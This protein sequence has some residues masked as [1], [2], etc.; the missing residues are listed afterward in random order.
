MLIMECAAIIIEVERMMSTL[1]P[2]GIEDAPVDDINMAQT[3][4]TLAGQ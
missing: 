4:E 2:N 1:E 3:G